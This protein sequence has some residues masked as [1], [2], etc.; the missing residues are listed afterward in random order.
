MEPSLAS[1]VLTEKQHPQVRGRGG[2]G[3]GQGAPAEGAASMH[4]ETRSLLQAGRTYSQE[5]DYGFFRPWILEVFARVSVMGWV[6]E[7]PGN[8]AL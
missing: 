2:Q 3:T 6:R 1:Q 5:P 7:G 8:F 4:P